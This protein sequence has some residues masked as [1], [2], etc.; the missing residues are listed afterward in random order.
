MNADAI[1][2][3]GPDAL[4]SEVM[5]QIAETEAREGVTRWRAEGL[6]T[7]GP[8]PA[9]IELSD[10]RELT[11]DAFMPDYRYWRTIPVEA[12]YGTPGPDAQPWRAR[13]TR[14]EALVM[15]AADVASCTFEVVGART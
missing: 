5:L 10:G 2:I 11:V 6:R 1:R 4:A 3:K 12:L 9:S 14:E 7:L 13:I 8:E 15:I